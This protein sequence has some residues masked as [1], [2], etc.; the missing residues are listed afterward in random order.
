[1]GAHR[2]NTILVDARQNTERR[3]ILSEPGDARFRGIEDE[4][5]VFCLSYPETN[6]RIVVKF[7]EVSMLVVTVQS[8]GS[9]GLSQQKKHPIRFGPR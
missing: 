1:M 4:Q 3:E 9:N 6:E 2:I 7:R 8:I 5:I